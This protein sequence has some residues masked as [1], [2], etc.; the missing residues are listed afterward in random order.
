VISTLWYIVPTELMRK[1]L[2]RHVESFTSYRD[3]NW[4]KVSLFSEVENELNLPTVPAHSVST[5]N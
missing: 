5:Y 3:K 1:R 2:L 4:F